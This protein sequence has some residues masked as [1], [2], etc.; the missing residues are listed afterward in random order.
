MLVVQYEKLKK[1][2]VGGVKRML[3]F[4]GFGYSQEEI[5][6][7]LKEGY[8]TFYRNHRDE[9]E[10]FTPPQRAFLTN[11]VN[12]TIQMLNECNVG[13]VFPIRDYL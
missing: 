10:H 3:D 8:T 13:D 6:K 1:D 12:E 2:T 11:M 9:F 4:L 7:R 5:G